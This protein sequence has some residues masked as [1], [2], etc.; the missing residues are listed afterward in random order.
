[1][2]D[3]NPQKL[4]L[5]FCDIAEKIHKTGFD[6]PWNKDSFKS[7]LALPTTIG[8]INEKGL[9][10]CSQVFDEMEILT[11]CVIPEL[12]QKGLGT[13]WLAHLFR[14]AATHGIKRIFLEVSV[15]NN[16]A[17]HLYEKNGFT[18]I[19]RRK[20]YYKTY[21]GLVDAICMEKILA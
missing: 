11:I 10:V 15:Q 9:L 21:D 7:L 19:G 20:N 6:F 8:W 4:T 14:Y 12:R 16:P 2:D 13:K 17:L 1:M 18:T 3:L 5:H